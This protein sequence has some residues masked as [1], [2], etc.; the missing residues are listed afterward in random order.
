MRMYGHQLG[1]LKINSLK[2]GKRGDLIGNI[3]GQDQNVLRKRW[4][5]KKSLQ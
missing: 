1:S 3:K 2:Q 4:V 5:A